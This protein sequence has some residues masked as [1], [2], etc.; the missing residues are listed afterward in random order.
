MEWKRQRR[1]DEVPAAVAVAVADFCRRA[2]SPAPPVDV[3]DAL[4]CLSDQ[5]EFRVRQLTDGEPTVTPLGPYAVVDVLSGTRPDLAARRQELGYYEVVREL[6]AERDRTEPVAHAVAAPPPP[7]PKFEPPPPVKTPPDEPATKAPPTLAEKIAPQKR[8]VQPH[9]AEAK[10]RGRFAQ[11][12]AARRPFEEL[13][14]NEGRALLEGLIAQH[15]HRFAV[16]RTLKAQFAGRRTN[17]V[18]PVDF[19]Y[20]LDKHQ[21]RARLVFCENEQ[22]LAAFLEHKGA[23]NRVAWAL[24]LSPAELDKLVKDNGIGRQVEE[25]RERFRREALAPRNLRQRLDLVGRTRY[26]AD[27]GIERRFEEELRAQLHALLEQSRKA[28]L[29]DAVDHVARQQGLS[30]ELLARAVKKLGLE[31]PPKAPAAH[32]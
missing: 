25:L 15:G 30:G 1:P 19:E 17:E 32:T 31:A 2:N 11:L 3:R 27:L 9:L 16:L 22:L 13:S 7:A 23:R 26:L 10:P 8:K 29:E 5:D 24:R 4:S 6:L 18:S 12:S 21:L 14:G 28:T 20:L